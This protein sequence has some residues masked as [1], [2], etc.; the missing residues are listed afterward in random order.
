MPLRHLAA[1]QNQPNPNAGP[2]WAWQLLSETL[3]TT[4]PFLDDEVGLKGDRL[5][6]KA[7]VAS[8]AMHVVLKVRP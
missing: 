8:R 3:A 5:P 7:A 4:A 2:V 6:E 1:D